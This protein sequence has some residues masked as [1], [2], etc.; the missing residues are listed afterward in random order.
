MRFVMRV[1]LL[2]VA[3]ALV[4]MLF[5]HQLFRDRHAEECAKIPEAEQGPAC[6]LHR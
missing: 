4:L 1:L 3:F 5:R 2:A 6:T